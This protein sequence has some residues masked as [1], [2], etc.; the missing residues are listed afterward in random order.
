MSTNL[1]IISIVFSVLL[2]I[3]VLLFVRKGK[4]TI[5][6]SLVWLSSTFVLFILCLFPNVLTWITRLIGIQVASNL[7]F[8]LI[9]GILLI[10]AISLTIIVSNQ[11]EKI[12]LLIQEVSILKEEKNE[13]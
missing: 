9:I 4:I 2:M 1:K 7:I 10:V 13:K 3:T 6:Y 11:T 12:R 8:A 5:R